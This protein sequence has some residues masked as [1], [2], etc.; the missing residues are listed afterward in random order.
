MAVITNTT[1][2]SNFVSVGQLDLLHKLWKMLD[3]PDQVYDEI[4]VGLD[5]GY[6][7]YSGIDRVIFPFASTGWLH[8]TALNSADEFRLFGQLR[9]TLHSGEAACLAI[10]YH[11]Q[12]TFLS[13]D[14]AARRASAELHVPV[15]GTLGVLLSLVQNGD[16]A[17]SKA[18]AILQQMMLAG[19]RSPITSLNEILG[20]P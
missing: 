16:L 20:K 10:A 2:I 1:L 19:Y 8:L 9:T 5:Q 15:S 4:Q 3:F 11:R 14:K 17:V 12:W 18:D 6:V 13:D 7:F